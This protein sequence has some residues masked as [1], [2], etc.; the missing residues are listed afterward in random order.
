MLCSDWGLYSPG[1]AMDSA[2]SC[3]ADHNL[4]YHC[5]VHPNQHGNPHRIHVADAFPKPNCYHICHANRNAVRDTDHNQIPHTI[6]VLMYITNPN[7][8][9]TLN[10]NSIWHPNNILISDF[11][12]H[13]K[14]ICN[15]NC[16]LI[17]NANFKHDPFFNSHL[18]SFFNTRSDPDPKPLFHIGANASLNVNIKPNTD[19]CVKPNLDGLFNINSDRNH[20]LF[21]HSSLN[22]HSNIN[23]DCNAI[24]NPELLTDSVIFSVTAL[25]CDAHPISH[26]ICNALFIYKC[27]LN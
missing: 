12:W 1:S 27:N 26:L 4:N 17:R 14:S 7:L 25:H 2:V 20:E 5:H 24:R 15:A 16:I 11:H 21:L 10:R 23:A 6:A 3:H 22:L 9:P 8:N 18:D 13:H 19:L